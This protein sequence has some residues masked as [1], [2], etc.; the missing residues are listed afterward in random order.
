MIM[1]KSTFLPC[2][3]QRCI[4]E[5]LR[6]RLLHHVAFPL[7]RFVPINPAPWPDE[8]KPGAYWVKMRLFSI[9]PLGRQ[10]IGIS[11]PVRS[12]THLQMRDDGHSAMIRMWDHWIIIKEAPGGAHYTDSVEIQAGLLTPVVWAFAWIFYGHRQRRWRS[13]VK[14]G[15]FG[16]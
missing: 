16:E 8:W 14:R 2:A 13:L 3:P 11:F 6:P 5:V 15:F 10:K 9:F 12:Q 1:E 4:A 7:V